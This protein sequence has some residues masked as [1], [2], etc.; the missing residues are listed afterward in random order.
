MKF[1]RYRISALIITVVFGCTLYANEPRE[2]DLNRYDQVIGKFKFRD[3]VFPPAEGSIVFVGSSSFWLWNTRVNNDL[4]PLT[5]VPRGFGGST[6]P[7]LLH[8]SDRIVIDYKPRAI[9]LYEG[10][11]D[12]G[13]YGHSP[14][15]VV[16]NFQ[17]FIDKVAAELPG[18]RIYIVS[19]K[20]S[21]LREKSWPVQDRANQ[22]LEKL[23]EQNSLLTFIDTATPMFDSDGK[24]RKDLFIDDDLHMNKKGYELWTSII[25]PI[26]MKNEGKYEKN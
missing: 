10:D 26:L 17:T 7:D 25:K 13:Y 6:M 12:I 15:Q 2:I 3:K 4:S 24:L 1:T 20:P 16:E 21:F 5:I 9:V 14:E 11:N 18:T 22:L 19:I 8:F 23:C